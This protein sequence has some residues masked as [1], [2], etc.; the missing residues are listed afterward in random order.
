MLRKLLHKALL[1]ELERVP[2]NLLAASHCQ[3]LQPCFP[4]GI[5]FFCSLFS[6]TENYN[7]T[8]EIVLT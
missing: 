6:S 7:S 2:R 5:M 4:E 1:S 3:I 8:L